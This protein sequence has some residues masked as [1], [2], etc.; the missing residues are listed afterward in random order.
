[1]KIN[2]DRVVTDRL[3]RNVDTNERRKINNTSVKRGG[4]NLFAKSNKERR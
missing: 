3:S 4:K 1:M 2:I